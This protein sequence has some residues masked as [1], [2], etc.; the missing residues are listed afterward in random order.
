[1]REAVA[2]SAPPALFAPMCSAINA[3]IWPIVRARI[4]LA[5]GSATPRE[6]SIEFSISTPMSESSPKSVSG[7]SSRSVSGFT[8]STE[9]TASR[10][11]CPMIPSSSSGAAD[12]ILSRKSLVAPPVS[13]PS[14]A[15]KM[16]SSK[17]FSCMPRK[18]CRHLAQST[19]IAI[20]CVAPACKG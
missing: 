13:W 11:A 19:R 7:W 6:P 8:R 3:T 1:M 12:S 5:C 14:T 16:C 2:T 9:P 15:A 20:T 18:N 4:R 10:T 17:G